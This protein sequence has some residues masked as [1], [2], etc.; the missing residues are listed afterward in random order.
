M[1]NHSSDLITLFFG[2]DIKKIGIL[3]QGNLSTSQIF[4][5][6]GKSFQS[7]QWQELI[8]SVAIGVAI[9]VLPRAFVAAVVGAS[10]GNGFKSKCGNEFNS[11]FRNGMEGLGGNDFKGSNGNQFKG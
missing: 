4:K 3:N 5:T 11:Y 10:C 6:T 2:L 7:E 1:L 8:L 9:G